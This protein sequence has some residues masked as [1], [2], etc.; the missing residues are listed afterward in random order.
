MRRCA[1]SG[2]PGPSGDSSASCE[3]RGRGRNSSARALFQ[4]PGPSAPQQERQRVHRPRPPRPP[5]AGGGRELVLC[6]LGARVSAAAIASRGR[7]RRRTSRRW[8]AQRPRLLGGDVWYRRID[9]ACVESEPDAAL[10]CAAAPA[11]RSS[12]ASR[13]AR[14]DAARRRW[15]SPSMPRTGTPGAGSARPGAIL[16]ECRGR[17]R[18]SLRFALGGRIDDDQVEA[19]APG[20]VP[21]AR[22]GRLQHLG[23]DR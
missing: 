1:R 2:R 3:A 15:D 19:A 14:P 23:R 17:P 16:L 11:S 13:Q 8:G 6:V 12:T 21:G 18:A 5:G 4:P 7:W 20:L 10:E 22:A 9:D